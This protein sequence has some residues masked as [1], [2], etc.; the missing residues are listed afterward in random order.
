VLAAGNRADLLVTAA[1]GASSMELLGVNRGGMGG[2]MGGSAA[3]DVGPIAALQVT[4][5]AVA[6]LAA[7]PFQPA[8]RD[9]RDAE[10][11]TRRRLVFDM[12]M[13]GGMSPGGRSFTIDGKEFD[14]DP[15]PRHIGGLSWFGRRVKSLMM[16]WG[17]SAAARRAAAM[18]TAP[19][20]RSA[21]V[22]ALRI[23]ASTAGALPVRVREAS[24]R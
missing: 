11:A 3:G 8:P 13:G 16:V 5:A 7:L 19:A 1:E 9:L 22:T 23:A 2:M 12:G 21:V 18:L 17:F 20:S 4:G 14:P 6:G 15:G 10:P 24:S